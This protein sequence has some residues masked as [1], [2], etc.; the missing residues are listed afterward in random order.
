LDELLVHI[1]G[2]P[3]Y[4]QAEFPVRKE[5]NAV[6]KEVEVLCRV[7]RST[8]VAIFRVEKQTGKA[9]RHFA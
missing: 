5:S 4:L 2:L 6:R 7:Y 3:A 9:G 8:A 1:K